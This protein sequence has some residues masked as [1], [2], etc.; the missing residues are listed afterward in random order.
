MLKM[1]RTVGVFCNILNTVDSNILT[2]ACTICNE[3]FTNHHEMVKHTRKWHKADNS[4]KTTGIFV[5]KSRIQNNPNMSKL[6]KLCQVFEKTH[7]PLISGLNHTNQVLTRKLKRDI[8]TFLRTELMTSTAMSFHFVLDCVLAKPETENQ[9]KRMRWTSRS[10]SEKIN[11]KSD[12]QLCVERGR[13]KL[14]H[15]LDTLLHMPSGS[16]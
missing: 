9:L 1:Q 6:S 13:V 3:G 10:V 14:Q 11:L 8:C 15:S 7:V 16:F 12:I 4:F 5:G 2:I